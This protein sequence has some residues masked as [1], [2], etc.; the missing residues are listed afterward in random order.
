MCLASA[1]NLFPN[2]RVAVLAWSGVG[3]PGWRRLLAGREPAVHRL[4]SLPREFSD[5][6]CDQ[7]RWVDADSSRGAGGV[8]EGLCGVGVLILWHGAQSVWPLAGALV[9]G[10]VRG[11]RCWAGTGQ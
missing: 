7:R 2:G 1:V 11:V 6:V 8:Y 10:G 5:L 3:W 9:H 4:D